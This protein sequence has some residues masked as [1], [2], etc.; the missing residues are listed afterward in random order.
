MK[1]KYLLLLLL[2][3]L[4]LLV[5]LIPQ[6]S[7]TIKRIRKA[8]AGGGI[9]YVGKGVK[10]SVRL[11]SDRLGIL[12]NFS[13]FDNLESARYELVYEASGVQQGAG[14]TVFLGDTDIKELLFATCSNGVCTFH[15][16]VQNARLSIVSTLKDGTT[17]LKPFR[18]KV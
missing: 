8:K 7:A 15:N 18:I 6:A 10:A 3:L 13:N 11:R 1:L 4:I 16:N 14:G 5:P 17:I 2:I 12:M 9:S